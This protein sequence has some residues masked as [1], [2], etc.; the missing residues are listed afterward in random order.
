[1]HSD[2][3]TLNDR[4]GRESLVHEVAEAVATCTPPQVFGI[5][6]DWG[7]GKTSFMHQVQWYLTADCP[8]Q[9]ES[10]KE[11]ARTAPQSTRDEY[12]KR[13]Q[14]V[15]F[16]A[17]RHQ[18]DDPPIV[19]LLHEMRAQ[20]G[21]APRIVRRLKRYASV[22][23]HGALLM[24][25]EQTKRIGLQYAKL[26]DA[27]REWQAN[28]LATELPS[29]ILR[30]HLRTAIDTLLPQSGDAIPSRLVVFVDDVD[31]CEP[32]I[33]Y[34]LLEGLKIYL[35]LE[36]C[37]FVLG[38]NEKTVANAIGKRLQVQNDPAVMQVRANAYM[39]KLCQNVWRL[40]AIRNPTAVLCELLPNGMARHWI[41]AAI[42]TVTTRCLPP[43]PRRLKGLANLIERFWP[44]LP[45]LPQ[46][47]EHR[48]AV[49][50][51]RRLLIVAYI[52]QFHYDLYARWYHDISLYDEIREW[53]DRGDSRH[54]FLKSLVLPEEV[55]RD[56]AS[57]R[58]ATPPRAMRSKYPDPT[59]ANVFWIQPLI[60]KLA[61]EATPSQFQRYL[62][63]VSA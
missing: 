43:N 3:P 22:G 60:Q 9:S 46:V 26:R 39:E 49:F 58:T 5:H 6:G 33:A 59:E 42:E 20:F 62:H 51:T 44:R 34:S 37:V 11:L 4:L 18:N 36:N 14:V 21:L 19:G 17:W 56:A 12:T 25:D 27:N 31:R 41:K 52:Y 28:E 10:E 13:I 32:E 29:Y 61:T 38:M 50:E 35:S 55:I 54:S 16:D 23:T 63:E 1:M 24:L 53:C 15:W 45:D 7:M 57:E 30:K 2:E 48:E 8:Q 40:P 47:A